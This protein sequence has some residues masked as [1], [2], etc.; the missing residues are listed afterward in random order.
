MAEYIEPDITLTRQPVPDHELIL[1]LLSQYGFDGFREEEGRI[2]AYIP[3]ESY[4]EKDFQAFMD[5]HRPD[6]VQRHSDA[7]RIFFR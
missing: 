4:C 5:R 7:E 1:A 2:L 3:V 6:T